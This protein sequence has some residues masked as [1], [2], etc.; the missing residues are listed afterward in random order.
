MMC[1]TTLSM[2]AWLSFV[3]KQSGRKR[4]ALVVTKAEKKNGSKSTPPL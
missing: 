4:Q 3:T 2:M 1:A